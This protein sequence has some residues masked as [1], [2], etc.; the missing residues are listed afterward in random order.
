MLLQAGLC[1]R[2]LTCIMHSTWCTS[3][4]TGIEHCTYTYTFTHNRVQ[5]IDDEDDDAYTSATLRTNTFT[6]KMSGMSNLKFDVHGYSYTSGQPWEG[7]SSITCSSGSCV[8]TVKAGRQ[9]S[10]R[11]ANWFKAVVDDGSAIAC[12]S[13][14]PLPNKLNF[15]FRGTMSF[16]YGGNTY[17]GKEIAIA[18]GHIN[19]QN[20]W[21]IGGPKMKREDDA[22][23]IT[24]DVKIYAMQYFT[25]GPASGYNLVSFMAEECVSHMEVKVH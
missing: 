6:L 24:G 4:I 3:L 16:D 18:Q 1:V 13:V 10:T 14:S 23:Y 20:N 15:G 21:W 9:G 7:I 11:V 2:G 22:N 5:V 19:A 8:L 12:D 25:F 17:V